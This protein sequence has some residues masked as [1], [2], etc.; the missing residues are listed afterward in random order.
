MKKAKRIP[1]LVTLAAGIALSACG[2]QDTRVAFDGIYFRTKARK[3]DDNRRAFTATV[4]RA[5]TTLDAARRAG[6]YEGTR[7]CIEN[8]GTSR[9]KWVVG[10]D[11]P[12]T[13]L[14]LT[15]GTLVFQG[16]CRT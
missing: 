1:L 9:I 6:E 4:P 2:S 7:Y 15:D 10:P 14:R 3:I 12:P 11:T 8:Y 16:E 5:S 13:S